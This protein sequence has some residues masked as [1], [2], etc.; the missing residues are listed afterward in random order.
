MRM[1][2][3]YIMIQNPQKYA[4]DLWLDPSNNKIN[5]YLE[6]T[7]DSTIIRNPHLSLLLNDLRIMLLNVEIDLIWIENFG[8]ISLNSMGNK[9]I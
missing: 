6:N 4:G 1:H 2:K 5:E 8:V 3:V 7:I 9:E